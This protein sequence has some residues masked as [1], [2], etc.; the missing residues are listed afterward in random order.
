MR[1]GRRPRGAAAIRFAQAGLPRPDTPWREAEWCVVD[2]ELTGL[3]RSD[4]I[5]S[6]GAVPVR[7]GALILGES[8]YTLARP[9][10]APTHA[11]VLIHKLRHADLAHAPSTDD[12]IELLLAT[13]A[14]RVPVFHTSMV[15]RTFLGRELRRR[16][17]RLPQDA[18]TEVLGRRFLRERDGEAP[19]GLS[20]A[21]LAR[22]LGQ[23]GEDPH[24]A[25][26]DALTTGKAFIALASLLDARR[27]Q[28]VSSLTATE[29]EPLRVVRFGPF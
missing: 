11:S 25:L 5:I 8:L 9:D 7:Q 14:G 19:P 18:D 29:Q 2:L 23:P 26:G 21:R 12:A 6:I 10:R 28:T 20:L 3:A 24:H 22:L 27:S 17:L 13:M 16:G 1:F 4:E 15:E